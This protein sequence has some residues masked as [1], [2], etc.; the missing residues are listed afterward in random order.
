MYVLLLDCPA[1]A[2]DLLLADLWERGT[3]GVQ[4]E[5]LPGGR[6]AL[7]AF[8]N[9]RFEAPSGARWE[10]AEDRDWVALSQSLWHPLLVGSRFFLAPAWNHDPT[11]PGRLRLEMQPGQA[12]GTGWSPATQSA[13]E[14]LES[15]LR[16]GATVLDLGTGSGILA[17]AAARL[18][19]GR[20]YA[21]DID[22]AAAQVAQSRFR[23]E[24]I[25]VGLFVG[26]LRA[27]ATASI[28]LLVANLNA[29][30]LLHLAPEIERIKKPGGL[31]VLAGFTPADLPRLRPAFPDGAFPSAL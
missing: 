2:K 23:A 24:A 1:D 29:E 16:P 10:D 8:F 27:V 15:R 9:A 28:D 25:E 19:A 12:C 22:P 30:T 5:D 13:L 21:C 14:G 17:V 7:K 31:A 6:C 26:S 20:V 3:A 11:P 18:G 4:E